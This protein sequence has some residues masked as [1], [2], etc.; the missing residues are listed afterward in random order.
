M[1]SFGLLFRAIFTQI[2]YNILKA[3][4]SWCSYDTFLNSFMLLFSGCS[5]SVL[6]VQRMLLVVFNIQMNIWFW[7]VIVIILIIILWGQLIY[8]IYCNN[9]Q[10]S[11][12][13]VFCVVKNSPMAK[14]FYLTVLVYTI[15]AYLITIISYLSIIVFSCNQ[16]LN[17]LNLNIDK[18]IVYREC[19]GI[20]FRSLLF[21]IPYMLIYSGRIYTWIYEYSTG[22]PRTWTMEYVSTIQV[23]TCVVVNCLTILYMHKEVKNDFIKL[24][25]K[26]K[27]IIYYQ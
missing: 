25:I 8:L 22:K 6:S 20:I 5:L 2:P 3:H 18:Q 19:R 27:T 16:C 14:L 13:G 7:L 24:L 11:I 1:A 4:Y 21:L 26:L 17:Q 12:I 9:I 10:I 23:S 15:S